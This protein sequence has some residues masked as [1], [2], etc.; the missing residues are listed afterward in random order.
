MNMRVAIAAL[1]LVTSGCLS[2]VRDNTPDDVAW[3]DYDVCKAE[4]EAKYGL[5]V[6]SNDP[7]YMTFMEGCM[8][9]RGYR[10]ER[11]PACIFAFRGC[12]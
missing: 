10:Y 5:F 12:I 11:A 9:K 3:K 4:A 7:L 8:E 1:F 2:Y 6:A